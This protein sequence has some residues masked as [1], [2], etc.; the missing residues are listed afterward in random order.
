[1]YYF[2]LYDFKSFKFKKRKKKKKSGTRQPSDTSWPRVSVR[3]GV[4]L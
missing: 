1:M 4:F 3:G 2:I